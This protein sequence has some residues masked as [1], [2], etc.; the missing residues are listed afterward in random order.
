MAE[1]ER[2]TYKVMAGADLVGSMLIANTNAQ[3]VRDSLIDAN[4]AEFTAHR[5]RM[6]IADALRGRQAR[7]RGVVTEHWEAL[8]PWNHPEWRHKDYVIEETEI[9]IRYAS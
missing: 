3:S 1:T 8:D 7:V 2:E 5:E 6:K 4:D 9:V